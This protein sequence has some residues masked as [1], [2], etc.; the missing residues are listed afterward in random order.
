MWEWWKET[1]KPVVAS[2][3]AHAGKKVK[4][5]GLSERERKRKLDVP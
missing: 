2:I 4:K 3:I 1:E 5:Y